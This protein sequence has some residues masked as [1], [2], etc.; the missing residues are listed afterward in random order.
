MLAL[1]EVILVLELYLHINAHI[2]AQF[3]NKTYVT[4]FKDF[5]CADFRGHEKNILRE[6]QKKS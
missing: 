1:I 3:S 2:Y 4:A 6:T 5:F